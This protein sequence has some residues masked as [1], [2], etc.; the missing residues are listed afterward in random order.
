MHLVSLNLDDRHLDVAVVDEDAIAGLDHARQTGQVDGDSF[1]RARDV[2]RLDHKRLAALQLDRLHDQLANAHFGAG[3]IAHDGDA[4][5]LGI[6]RCAHSSDRAT[7]AVEVAMREVQTHDVHARRNHPL[8]RVLAVGC[9][10]DGAD[11]LGLLS[12]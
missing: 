3:Q 9:G 10:A 12:G 4:L 2:F 7:V 8:Q 6:S 5:A 1:A 11:D